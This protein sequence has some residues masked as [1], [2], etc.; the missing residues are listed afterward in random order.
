MTQTVAAHRR[1]AAILVA[2]IVGYTRL[3]EAYEEYT[4]HWQT[5][6]RTEILDPVVA[7]DAGQ[8]VKNTGDGFVAIFDSA[9]AATT[10]A[11]ALQQA[12]AAR[13]VEQ[14][15]ER[16]ISYRMAVN[17]AEIIVEEDDVYGDGVNV[18]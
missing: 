3:M 1:H 5:L 16:R 10:C 7:G 15:I 2:D 14:P 6:L 4:Y 11:L 8:M 12:V 13:T 17:V 18:A 9:R